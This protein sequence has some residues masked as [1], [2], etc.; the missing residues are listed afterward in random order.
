MT[1]EPAS[2]FD[3]VPPPYVPEQ[4]TAPTTT[5]KLEAPRIR[6]AG[7]VWGTLFAVFSATA[8]AVLADLARRAAVRDAIMGL[9]DL[10]LSPAVIVAVSV[11]AVGGLLA[12]I[13]VTT[14]TRRAR[15]TIER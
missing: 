3:S 15:L 10:H 9:A 12:V 13:G 11:L 6:W 8:L 14:L 1:F 7:I 5:E 2:T 4:P